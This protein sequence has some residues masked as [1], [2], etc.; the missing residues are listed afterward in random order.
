MLEWSISYHI[1]SSTFSTAQKQK[2]W[3]TA[4]LALS[5]SLDGH[6]PCD[7]DPNTLVGPENDRTCQWSPRQPQVDGRSPALCGGPRAW[8]WG[9]LPP[10]SL[11]KKKR[12]GPS[13]SPSIWRHACRHAW[14]PWKQGGISAVHFLKMETAALLPLRRWVLALSSFELLRQT[15]RPAEP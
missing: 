2:P 15:F 11:G 8:G 3:E 12:R 7:V 5:E 1:L 9:P 6:C 4:M 10:T 14:S 13:E